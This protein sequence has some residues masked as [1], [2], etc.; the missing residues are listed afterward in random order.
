MKHF[1][2]HIKPAKD[3]IDAVRFEQIDDCIVDRQLITWY[4]AHL[5]KPQDLQEIWVALPD[6]SLPKGKYR[7]EL[8]DFVGR[9]VAPPLWR[10][11]PSFDPIR[12][13]PVYWAEV[14]RLNLRFVQTMKDLALA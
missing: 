11:L 9:G 14:P 13:P 6:S 3:L 1:A 7:I 4:P 8:A 10:S 2:Q 12:V 5:H